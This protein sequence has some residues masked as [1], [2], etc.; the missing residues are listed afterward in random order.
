MEK[1]WRFPVI[2]LGLAGILIGVFVFRKGYTM[3]NNLPGRS[4]ELYKTVEELKGIALEAAPSEQNSSVIIS[5][6]TQTTHGT[7]VTTGVFSPSYS[8]A[9]DREVYLVTLEGVFTFSRGPRGAE[10]I[11]A[12]HIN[13]EIDAT[14]GEV[15]SM[16]TSTLTTDLVYVKNLASQPDLFWVNP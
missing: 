7:L 8:V 5:T 1:K 9:D 2:I 3:P 4:G 14:T 10:P 11:Q 16:G 15:L 13:I 6:L 12:T